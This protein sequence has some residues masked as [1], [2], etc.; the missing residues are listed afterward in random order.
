[1][2]KIICQ[3]NELWLNCHLALNLDLETNHRSYSLDERVL[4]V[5]RITEGLTEVFALKSFLSPH[6]DAVLFLAV[7]TKR[8]TW[9]ELSSGSSNWINEETAVRK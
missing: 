7:M 8:I 6:R 2:G 5:L 3:L 9:R 4:L 1:M